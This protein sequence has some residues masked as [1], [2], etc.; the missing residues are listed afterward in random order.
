MGVFDTIT[1]NVGRV[2]IP[3]KAEF[4][5]NFCIVS[6]GD[7][8]LDQ[9]T[10]K[11]ATAED[12]SI[13]V[14]GDNETSKWLKSF[15][16][17]ARG[18]AVYIFECGSSGS[19]EEK[20]KRL[21]SFIDEGVTP[22]W[23]YSFPQALYKSPY[24]STL[25]AKYNGE[26]IAVYFSAVQDTSSSTNPSEQTEYAN[27]KGQKAFMSFY[28]S[29]GDAN[30][31]IDGFASGV[32]ASSDFDIDSSNQMRPLERMK[33]S[34]F[35]KDL[36]ATINKQIHDAP[37]VLSLNDGSNN[38]LRNTKMADGYFWHTR[39]A[40]DYVIYLIKSNIDA[41]FNTSADTAGSAIKY[42]DSG[43]QSV[44][45][46]L[47][48]TLE[49]ANS[50][51]LVNRFGAS[52]DISTGKITGQGDLSAISFEEYKNANPENYAEGIYGGF[53]GYVEI[54]GFI[55]KIVFNVTLG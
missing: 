9:G 50:L 18:K 41:L 28:P 27:W 32:M 53:S 29:L 10:I 3:A 13:Y 44:K 30:Y 46:N 43:I 24:L 55:V 40:Q 26:D 36:G 16:V 21:E 4:L 8:N 35:S 52:L 37:C 14:T 5:R 47:I 54:Q 6:A 42:N 2:S 31:N 45:Q 7:S 1:I 19:E 25:L 22:C 23:K 12:W 39:Y 49:N 15:F 20:L 48:T 34:S 17:K 11:M 51:G 33:I 38:R